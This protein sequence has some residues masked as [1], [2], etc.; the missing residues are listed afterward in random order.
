MGLPN[1][2]I[3]FPLFC[4]PLTLNGS[5]YSASRP[6]HFYP[7][8]S[9]SDNYWLQCIMGPSTDLGSAKEE[10]SLPLPGIETR[11]FARPFRSTVSVL[12][13]RIL[14]GY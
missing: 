10:K 5:D 1:P 2:E 13:N 9:V 4:A 12:T 8:E 3:I 7:A 6:S 11:F 14:L